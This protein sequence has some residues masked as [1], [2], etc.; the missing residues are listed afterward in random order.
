MQTLVGSEDMIKALFGSKRVKVFPAFSPEQAAS[1]FEQSLQLFGKA[2]TID[3]SGYLEYKLFEE[4]YPGNRHMLSRYELISST[5]VAHLANFMVSAGIVQR[6]GEFTEP[7]MDSRV[8][9]KLFMTR[10]GKLILA[11]QYRTS[12]EEPEK[13]VCR[14]ISHDDLA[15]MFE[16][17]SFLLKTMVQ[18][19]KSTANRAKA[20]V[21]ER[22][23]SLNTLEGKF[24]ELSDILDMTEK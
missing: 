12:I 18:E 19:L 3:L 21:Q 20:H 6:W 16:A 17:D 4:H 8:N 11:A 24:V 1:F 22:V 23:D 13:R 7:H 14:W 15:R 5:R 9:C 2:T 10:P